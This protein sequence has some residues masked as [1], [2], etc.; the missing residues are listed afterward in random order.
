MNHVG[1]HEFTLLKIY[2]GNEFWRHLVVHC[3]NARTE[4]ELFATFFKLEKFSNLRH[5]VQ[6]AKKAH[7]LESNGAEHIPSSDKEKMRGKLTTCE[8]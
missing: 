8:Q 6:G 2:Q 3:K 1:E 7:S 5:C 4:K